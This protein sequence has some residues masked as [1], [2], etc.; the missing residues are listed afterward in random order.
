MIDAVKVHAK[1]IAQQLQQIGI[2]EI[3]VQRLEAL[4]RRGDDIVSADCWQELDEKKLKLQVHLEKMDGDSYSF[5]GYDAAL[6]EKAPPEH[7]IFN[8]VDSKALEEKMKDVDWFY[9]FCNSSKEIEKEYK[10]IETI[11]VDLHRLANHSEGIKAAAQL[12]I[13]HVPFYAITKPSALKEFED[14]STLFPRCGYLPDMHLSMVPGDLTRQAELQLDL[15]PHLLTIKNLSM[16]EKE[17]AYARTELGRLGIS[18]AFNESLVDQM[19]QGEK[20]I[21]QP[22][23]KKYDNGD[24]AKAM[25]HWNKSERSNL[26]FL[27]KWDLTVKKSGEEKEVSMTFYVNDLKRVGHALKNPDRYVKSFTFKASVNY[28]C[29]RP[30]LNNYM[31]QKGDQYKAWDVAYPSEKLVNGKMKERTFHPAYGFDLRKVGAEYGSA[32]KDLANSEYAERF[33]KSLERGNLQSAKFVNRDG[34]EETLYVSPNIP[35]GYLNLSTANGKSLTPQQQAEKGFISQE[36]ADKVIHRIAQIEQE[37]QQHKQNLSTISHAKETGQVAKEQQH[38]SP[39]INASS[40]KKETT[41][42]H[43][44]NETANKKTKQALKTDGEGKAVKRKPKQKL[45]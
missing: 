21:L 2:T 28:L 17:L 23:Q 11:E 13:N 45:G 24:E 20:A 3:P 36:F 30:V 15:K 26:Y 42:S 37:K 29:G 43:R 22:F 34:K 35:V 33:Y 12:W 1:N 27:N 32:V 14:R 25:L 39:V 31:N 8:N 9:A 38:S 6:F 16:M 4:L 18:E 44:Q 40:E 41:K 7:G 10:K 19:R 5:Y